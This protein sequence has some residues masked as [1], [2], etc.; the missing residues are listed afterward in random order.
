[1]EN[2]KAELTW[3]GQMGLWVTIGGRTVSIDYFASDL[4]GRQKRPPVPTGEVSGS[5]AFLGTHDHLDHIDHDSWKIWAETCP[6][7]VFVFPEA[8][9][10]SVAADG[11]RPDRLKGMYEGAGRL[12]ESLAS[13]EEGFICEYAE[14]GCSSSLVG[15]WDDVGPPVFF[16]PSLRG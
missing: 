13:P 15:R 7:A 10:K 3:M 1:M 14:G 11:I 4:E 12:D 5:D 16:Q 6:D 9:R 2:R 8:C